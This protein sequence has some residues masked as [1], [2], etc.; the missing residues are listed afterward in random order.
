M[1]FYYNSTKGYKR[2][3][4]DETVRAIRKHLEN[5][6]PDLSIYT[7]A[8]QLHEALINFRD[9]YGDRLLIHQL[10]PIFTYVANNIALWPEE[11]IQSQ[12]NQYEKY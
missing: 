12:V 9:V 5:E 4:N 7:T 10:E 8:G 3:L 6:I 2:Q 1:K 11:P